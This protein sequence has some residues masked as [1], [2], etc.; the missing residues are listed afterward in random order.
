M[1]VNVVKSGIVK[2]FN[3]EKGYG[4]I[5]PDDGGSDV[6]VHI[7]ALQKVGIQQLIQGQRVS[8]EVFNDGGKISAVNVV[9]LSFADQQ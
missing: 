5:V 1:A 4:F 7:R 2:W 6:F 8:Y 9:L 3:I